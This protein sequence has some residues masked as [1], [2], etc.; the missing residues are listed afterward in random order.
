[1]MN[2]TLGVGMTRSSRS[3]CGALRHRHA[4]DNPA[5]GGFMPP[6]TGL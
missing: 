3:G 4:H 1:V 5:S 6:K 2:Q